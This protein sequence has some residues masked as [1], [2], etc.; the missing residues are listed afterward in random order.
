[1]YQVNIPALYN[2][3]TDKSL[4]KIRNVVVSGTIMA[5]CLYIV[6]G[7]FGYLTFSTSSKEELDRIFSDNI[8][9]APYH[10]SDSLTDIPIVI[11]I[12]LFGMCIVVAI[13]TPFCVL[14]M[15]DGLEEIRNKKFSKNENVFY[16][17][18]LAA[19]P[20]IFSIPF[21]SISTPM[22]IL[23]ATT[24]SAVGFFLPIAYYLRLEK[25]S[26]PWTNMK[27]LSYLIFG[28]V[29]LSSVVELIL[30]IVSFV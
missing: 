10:T 7:I 20:A 5:C 3:L 13:A 8:L 22:A 1:M 11:Y 25:K 4:P 30:L 26:S 24:N 21:K 16:T 29:A 18:L 14:P 6:A 9:K 17:L 12:S 15:K 27:I 28:F 19:I 23:G 2:E